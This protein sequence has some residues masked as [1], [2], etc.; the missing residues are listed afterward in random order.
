MT[1]T[2][3]KKILSFLGQLLLFAILYFAVTEWQARNLLSDSGDEKAPNFSLVSLQGD[4]YNLTD[5]NSENTVV[6]FFA[7]WCSVC[8]LS[9]G[10]LQNLRESAEQKDVNIV[11]VA[12]DWRAKE[13]VENFIKDH[14]LTFPVL[15]GNR[16]VSLDYKIQGFPTYYV[17]DREKN[18]TKVSMGYSSE[19][20]L[21]YN[22]L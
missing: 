2:H 7:T 21:R 18:I 15:L 4:V 6:Y 10:N 1:K 11:A 9:I 12:L 8:K 5:Y 19:L 3:L 14:E 17:L 16:Q 22:V 13:E 20:G